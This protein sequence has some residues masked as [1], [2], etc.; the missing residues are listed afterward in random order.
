[1]PARTADEAPQHWVV[2]KKV[3]LA[4]LAA[5]VLQTLCLVAGAA[6]VITRF[7][8]RVTQ[9]EMTDLRV[10]SERDVRRKAVDDRFEMMARDRDRLI[11]LEVGMESVT[12]SL[13]RIENKL[14]TTR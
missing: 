2:E 9:L 1:M 14:D 11:R 13:N 10:I 3:N 12:K 8:S 7:D 4:W 5:M 6:A